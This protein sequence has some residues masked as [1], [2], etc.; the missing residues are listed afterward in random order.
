MEILGVSVHG[1]EADYNV[2]VVGGGEERLKMRDK[3]K[4]WL[5]YLLVM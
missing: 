4:S 2:C 1:E 5:W 3:G